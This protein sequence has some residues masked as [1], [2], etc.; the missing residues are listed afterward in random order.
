MIMNKY[1]RWVVMGAALSGMG[2]AMPSCPGQQAMQEK[3]D[4]L[5]TSE[6]ELNKKVQAM[7]TQITTLNNDMAQVK[8]LLPQMTNVI[9]AQKGALE[10]LDATVKSMQTKAK[11]GAGKKKK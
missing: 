4:A 8:Q 6:T 7:Q 2:I 10:Q 11:P 3:I 5:Q 1:V 9:Q